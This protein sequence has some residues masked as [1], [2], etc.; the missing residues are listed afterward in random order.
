MAGMAGMQLQMIETED[1]IRLISC[2]SGLGLEKC[3][4][5]MDVQT[6]LDDGGCP[7][8]VGVVDQFNPIN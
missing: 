7:Y 8:D 6:E 2:R 4:S 3:S 1:S 5:L